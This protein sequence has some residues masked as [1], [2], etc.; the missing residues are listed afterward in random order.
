MFTPRPRT[1]NPRLGT[2]FSIFASLFAALFV[3]LFIFEQLGATDSLLRWAMLVVP[4]ALYIAIGL[5]AAT[6]DPIRYFASGRR[7]PAAYNGV[8]IGMTAFGGTGL[9]A[10]TGVFFLIGFDALCLMIGGL[11]GFV[12]MA[13]LLAP[14]LRKFGSYTVPSYLGRRFDSRILR[15]VVGAL[16][17]VPMLL[18]LAAELQI[19]GQAAALLVGLSPSTG[20]LLIGCVVLA[21]VAAGGM[22]AMT[23]SGAAKIIAALMALMVPVTTVA[24]LVTSFPLPQ[25]TT[26]PKLRSFVRREA[27]EGLTAKTASLFAFDMPSSGFSVMAKPFT[28]AFGSIGPAA[29]TLTTLTLMAGVAAAPWL[30]PRVATSASVYETRKS[31]AWA[32]FAF[33]VVMLTMAS[34][35]VFMRDIVME[36]VSIGGPIPGWLAS[37]QNLGFVE[38][39][40]EAQRLRLTGMAFDRDTVLFSLPVAAELPNVL[41]YLALAGAVAAALAGA[42][43]VASAL[44]NVLAEDIVNGWWDPGP[45]RGRLWSARLCLVFA[46]GVSFL[47]AILAPTDSLTLLFWALALSGST[48]FPVLVMSIWW[49]KINTLGAL[50][51]VTTGFGIAVLAIMGFEAGLFPLNGALAGVVA[52]PLGTGAAILATVLTPAPSSDQI[53]ALRDMRVASG[54]ILEDR[55]TLRPKGP[56]MSSF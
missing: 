24:I 8:A 53:G 14:F 48:A 27:V 32:T 50:A 15:I 33:G 42:A 21:C 10:G 1:F 3:L 18:M 54:D 55:E 6:G 7:V 35:G 19:G 45:P 13:V 12:V 38:T 41:M 28:T 31:L 43:A 16:L 29:F 49:K 39:A 25:L 11:A 22:R 9:V 47:M 5:G 37:L 40:T 51:G 2:Y 36:Y 17:G 26:G 30:L 46:V 56:E 4:L 20:T 23:W 52:I 44:G 34:V